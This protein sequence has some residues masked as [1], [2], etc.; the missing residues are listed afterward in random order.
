MAKVPAILVAREV[1][2]GEAKWSICGHL[3]MLICDGF[4]SLSGFSPSDLLAALPGPCSQLLRFRAEVLMSARCP[5]AQP[6]QVWT[7]LL[8]LE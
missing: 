8:F 6:R 2:S 7:C 4:S 1:K 5:E 3:A